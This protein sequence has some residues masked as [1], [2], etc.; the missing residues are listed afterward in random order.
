MSEPVRWS[1]RKFWGAM[2]WE[3]VMV[4]LLVLG[5]LPPDAFV[6]ITIVI[7][8]GYFTANVMAK[9]FEGGQP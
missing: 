7:L 8:G 2:F 5:H 3:S 9:K 4:L 6:T 1:S